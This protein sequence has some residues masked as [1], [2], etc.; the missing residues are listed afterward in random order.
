MSTSR[1]QKSL[2]GVMV[3]VKLPVPSNVTPYEGSRVR[4]PCGGPIACHNRQRLSQ[5]WRHYR[6]SKPSG[7]AMLIARLI[8]RT[9]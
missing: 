3:P 4:H 8:W 1:A 7:A 9:R 6:G 2:L 5:R